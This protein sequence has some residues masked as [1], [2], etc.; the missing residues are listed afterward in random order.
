MELKVWPKLGYAAA[1]HRTRP[2][3]NFHTVG[4]DALGPSSRATSGSEK[5][6]TFDPE[7]FWPQ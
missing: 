7:V 3:K 2:G 5:R 4:A 1:L 6:R